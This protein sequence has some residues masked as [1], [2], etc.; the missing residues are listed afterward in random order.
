MSSVTSVFGMMPLVLTPGPGSEFYRGLGSVVVGG[1][2]VSTVFTIFLV[3]A[4]LSL[5]LD[6]FGAIERRFRSEEA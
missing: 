5:V 4:L 6:A 1:L 3:P 2:L